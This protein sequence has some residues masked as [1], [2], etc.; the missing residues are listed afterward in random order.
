MAAGR[1]VAEGAS[2]FGDA[3]GLGEADVRECMSS[4]RPAYPKTSALIPLHGVRAALSF[5]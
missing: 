1:T 3:S 5:P 4:V 2:A